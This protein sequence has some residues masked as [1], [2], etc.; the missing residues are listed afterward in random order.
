MEKL[1]SGFLQRYLSNRTSPF[2]NTLLNVLNHFGLIFG[3]VRLAGSIKIGQPVKAVDTKV[4]VGTIPLPTSHALLTPTRKSL[5]F[6][7]SVGTP[8]MW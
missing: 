6:D 7:M 2:Q 4:D 1:A 3:W 5:N 8:D